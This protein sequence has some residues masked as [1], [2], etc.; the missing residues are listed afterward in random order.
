MRLPK[1]A[2]P[3]KRHVSSVKI[4]VENVG[5]TQSGHFYCTA[6]GIACKLTPIPTAICNAIV[7]CCNNI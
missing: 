7:N 5:V 1:Q 6:I 4:S 2:Q 3:V